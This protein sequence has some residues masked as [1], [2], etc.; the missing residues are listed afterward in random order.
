[1]NGGL[2]NDDVSQSLKTRS[3]ARV[4]FSSGGVHDYHSIKVE[5]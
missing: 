4:D 1:M 3:R 2:R 5:V